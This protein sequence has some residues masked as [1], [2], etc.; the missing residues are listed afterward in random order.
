MQK[1]T[2]AVLKLQLVKEVAVLANVSQDEAERLMDMRSA[3]ERPYRRSAPPRTLAP[4][5]TSQEQNLLRC[6]L[7]KPSLA[8]S[9]ELELLDERLAETA[10]LRTIAGWLE[11]E[12]TPSE[13]LL[14]ERMQ[15]SEHEAVVFRA[16]A[17]MLDHGP[18]E[19]S[20]EPEFRQIVLSLHIKRKNEEIESLKREAASRP[21][22]G[23]ELAKRTKELAAL[24]SQ[25]M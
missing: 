24:K 14:V 11:T 6:V 15:G 9:M 5:I 2:A 25:R 4:L 19:D 7:A 16:Q 10:A 23:A 22:L 18:N 20:A 13:A 3:N 1:I 12:E 8:A 17:A 21:E